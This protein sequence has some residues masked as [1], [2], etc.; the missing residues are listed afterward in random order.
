M[1]ML[2][3]VAPALSRTNL[4]TVVSLSLNSNAA[5][6]ASALRTAP[7]GSTYQALTA[8][9]VIW[10]IIPHRYQDHQTHPNVHW[11]RIV[12][13]LTVQGHRGSQAVVLGLVAPN[14][15]K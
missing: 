5:S 7:T 12:C 3:L 9:C 10:D 8:T 6:N 13:S 15:I 1:V 14:V 2:S 4:P 11:A